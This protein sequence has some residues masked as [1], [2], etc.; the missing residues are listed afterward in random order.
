M[1]IQ[2]I[3]NTGLSFER[4]KKPISKPLEKSPLLDKKQEV[5]KEALSITREV[6][7]IKN[8]MSIV[9][10]SS[11]EI[12]KEAKQIQEKC[13]EKQAEIIKLLSS[14]EI[15]DEGLSFISDGE[16]NIKATYETIRIKGKP[17]P[18]ITYKVQ[19]GNETKTKTK[20]IVYPD[21]YEI[22]ETNYTTNQKNRYIYNLQE[23][24]LEAYYENINTDKRVFEAEKCYL[25]DRSGLKSYVSEYKEFKRGNWESKQELEFKD[26]KLTKFTSGNKRLSTHFARFFEIEAKFDKNEHLVQFSKFIVDS[27]NFGPTTNWSKVFEFE[28]SNLKTL[29]KSKLNGQ[30]NKSH[31]QFIFTFLNGQLALYE[32]KT[33]NIYPIHSHNTFTIN[34]K[35]EV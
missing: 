12:Q 31:E 33:D 18:S 11:K 8:E 7:N 1:Q 13:K 35:N 23:N 16:K 20:V 14:D 5:I 30:R 29:T 15:N 10:A 25:F 26:N 4:K 3:S 19:T 22:E 27:K 24:G 9:L 34:F 17:L 32:E 6:K 21:K 28:N 2:Y